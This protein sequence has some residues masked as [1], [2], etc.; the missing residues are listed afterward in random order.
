MGNESMKGDDD[1]YVGMYKKKLGRKKGFTGFYF[2][3]GWSL[4]FFFF[5]LLTLLSLGG[6]VGEGRSDKVA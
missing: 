2:G 5:F 6:Y 1:G 3:F 4:C